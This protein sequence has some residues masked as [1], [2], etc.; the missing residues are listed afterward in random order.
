MNRL[1]MEN[2][3][4]EFPDPDK[5]LDWY[6][7]RPG[8]QVHKV[9]SHIHTP[10]SFSAFTDMEQIFKQAREENIK[11]L[12]INDF[13]TTDGFDDFY[14]HAL[15]YRVFPLFNIEFVGL[16]REAQANNTR[17]NDPNNP[18]RI[19]F[20]GKG[21]GYP[22]LWGNRI[23]SVI[24]RVVRESHIQVSAMID[25]VN[26]LFE[27]LDY[28]IRISMEEI[29]EKYAENLVRERHIAKAIRVKI[30]ETFNNDTER[31]SCLS[32]LFS[33]KPLSA[34]LVSMAALE[35]EIR[36][37]LLKKGGAA[38]VEEDKKAFMSFERIMEI[39]LDAGGIPCY[40]VLLDDKQGT[41]T[42]FEKDP[43]GLSNHLLSRY[44]SCI[45]LIPGRNSYD[46]LSKFVEFFHQKN[47]VILF[48]TEHNTPEMT[49]LTVSCRDN[50]PLDDKLK[51]VGFEGACVIAAHQYLKAKG[52]QG[53]IKENGAPRTDE[54]GRFTDL[55]KALIEKFIVN[56]SI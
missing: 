1:I 39:I 51:K 24:E 29:K 19:Y 40:P 5:I 9:N 32:D 13:F 16:M 17:I 8:L 22:V 10:W 3:L 34:G 53:F 15:A 46:V 6:S 36:S 20:C 12:G 43:E 14:Q 2:I 21:L 54:I 41:I 37:R 28:S 35:N 55:G 25:K 52:K 48:G 33:G 23:R 44:I 18:G 42:D 11:V 7:K 38:F 4:K 30:F 56:D 27:R 31:Q 50:V 45:E 49:P 47:F 26:M